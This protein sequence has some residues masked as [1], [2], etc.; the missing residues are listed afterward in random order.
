[1]LPF[2]IRSKWGVSDT[3]WYWGKSGSDWPTWVPALE[4][5]ERFGDRRDADQKVIELQ[6]IYDSQ[7][8][9]LP[10]RVIEVVLWPS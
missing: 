7:D 5:S 3:V 8:S 10:V 2:V 1:M 6:L 9:V 4:Q